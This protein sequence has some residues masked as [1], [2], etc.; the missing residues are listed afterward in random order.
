[1]TSLADADLSQ[2][3]DEWLDWSETA[4][5]LGVTPAKVRTMVKV[6]ELAAAVPA[7]GRG[8]AGA[9]GV[10]RHDGLVVKGLP[11][12]LT[13]LHDGG[14]DDREC[15]AWM[16]LDADLPGPPDRRPPREPRLGGQAACAGHGRLSRRRPAAGS[17]SASSRSW[18]WRSSPGRST[19]AA[20]SPEEAATATPTRRTSR[21]S[22]SPTCPPE[23]AHTVDL[24]EA[25][26]PF[27]YD[28]D[29]IVF[30]NREGLLPDEWIRLLPRVHRAHPGRERP[31]R[32]EDHRGLR[33]R[34]V[35]DRRPLPI[36]R[37]DLPMS[38]L[39]GLLAHHVEPGIYRW[40]GHFP[41]ED[42]RH[43]V[44]HAGWRFAAGRRL[45]PH[46]QG[47]VP[48]GGRRRR[49]DF[50]DYYG[51]NFDALADCLGDV[52]AGDSEGWVLLWDGWGPLAREDHRA[53]SVALSVLGGRVNADKGG[54]F[55]VLL[56]GD[57]PDVAG[58]PSLGLN[59]VR[60]P[61]R[62]RRSPARGVRRGRRSS[63]SAAPRA[64]VAL[65]ARSPI[66]CSTCSW[67]PER[68]DDPRA[69]RRRPTR[70]SGVPSAASS[71]AASADGAAVQGEGDE[72]GALALDQVV[73]GGLAGRGRVAEDAEQVVT[74]LEGLAQ[75]KA[76]GAELP[77]LRPACHR[78]ASRRCAAAARWSTSP[79]CSAAPSSRRRRPP[80]RAPAP[81]RRGTGR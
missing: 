29:G 34:A 33:R 79:T 55:A 11:G 5:I 76:E 3:V 53:F 28:R 38:G 36:V 26:G 56:R 75:G 64:V 8:A 62:W 68:V 20:G 78:P 2:L 71:R 60:R 45:A 48:R 21:G 74:Q 54:R 6:H 15:I 35:L 67:A 57:G 73:A 18:R 4:Q 51:Q 12:L 61:G 31:R 24:I 77:E 43:T 47:G 80:S 14:Y 59:R 66:T 49:S 81:T 1:M 25:G 16:F 40:H 46:D 72:H 39:A 13:V 27:P 65:S 50:P 42:V 7:P 58:V 69:A 9:G 30:E 17:G 19:R 70:V 32:P 23:A 10:P 22:R 63:R 52:T 41:V 37:E 44:E